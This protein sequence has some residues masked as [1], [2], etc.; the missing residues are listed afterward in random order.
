MLVR[1]VAANGAS[2]AEIEMMYGLGSGTIAKWRKHYPGFDKALTEGRTVV[3]GDV[4]FA[5]Y[6]NAVGFEFT[7]EQAVGGREPCVMRVKRF[8]PGEHAAQKYWLNNRRKEQ[9]KTREHVD[10]KSTTLHGLEPITRNSL[11]ESIV[12]LVASKPDPEKPR[13]KQDERR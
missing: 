2:D 8:K 6:K 13:N 11:I 12:K 1:M 5:A 7:E 3:D 9:W 10:A 4:L